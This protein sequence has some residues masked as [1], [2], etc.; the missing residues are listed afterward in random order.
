MTSSM[1]SVGWGEEEVRCTGLRNQRS[2]MAGSQTLLLIRMLQ[3][4]LL[5]RKWRRFRDKEEA[6]ERVEQHWGYNGASR[7]AHSNTF[8]LFYRNK[9]P[10]KWKVLAFFISKVSLIMPRNLSFFKET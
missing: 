8:E 1:T 9:I 6:A 5:I 4:Q 7:D 2:R 3:E 10:N